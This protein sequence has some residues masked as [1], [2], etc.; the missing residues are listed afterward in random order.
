LL[1]LFPVNVTYCIIGVL[2]TGLG[3]KSSLSHC[4][5]LLQEIENSVGFYKNLTVMDQSC[6]V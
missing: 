5:L 6:S 4:H 2:I 3:Y 1:I